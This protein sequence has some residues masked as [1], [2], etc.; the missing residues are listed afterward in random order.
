MMI[1]GIYMYICC[2]VARGSIK[3]AVSLEHK[4][5]EAEAER[6]AER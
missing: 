1:I 2:I 6:E 4:E 3:G 5:A